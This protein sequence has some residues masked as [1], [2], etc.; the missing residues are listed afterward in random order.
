MRPCSWLSHAAACAF[1]AAS[2]SLVPAPASAQDVANFQPYQA[3]FEAPVFLG[4]PPGE[5]N[6]VMIGTL[7]GLI[8]VVE[9]GVLLPTPFLD[10]SDRVRLVHGLIGIA[11][12]PDYAVSRRFYVNYT[13]PE[14]NGPRISRFTTSANPNVSN[15]NEE[16]LLE[17]GPGQGD[18]NSGWMDFGPDGYLYIAKGDSFANP[19]D[20]VSHLG[21]KMLRIDVSPAAGY[22]CPPD[23]PYVGKPGFDEIAAIGLRN[24]WRNCFDKLTGDLYIADVGV[25][26]VEEVNYVPA[27]TLLGRNFGWGCYE[28]TICRTP[29]PF[30]TCDCNDPFLTFPIHTY[31]HQQGFSIIGGPVYRGDAIPRWRGRYFYMDPFTNRLWSLRTVNGAASDVQEHAAALNEGLP[32]GQSLSMGVTIGTDGQGEM[33]VLELSGRIIKIVPEH[34]AADWDLNGVVNSQDFFSFL[35][36]LFDERADLTGDHL[37]N[38][39]DFFEFLI[40]FFD[41]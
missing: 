38:S 29:L 15:D 22:V 4:S 13:P 27:G 34:D 25:L 14:L 5:P 21:G 3:G 30:P 6:R 10:I 16:V 26:D 41:R 24:P 18:H 23:N 8:F 32:S 17:T 33:Y 35:G 37:T 12:A 31:N 20:P 40:Y 39:Q 11:F 36:D 1:V 7:R 28:G 19:Q 9:D 2:C